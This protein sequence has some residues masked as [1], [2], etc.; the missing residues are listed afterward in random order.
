MTPENL[1]SEWAR[2]LVVSLADAGLRDLVVSPGSRSTPVV[3]AAL[4]S[5]RLRMHSVV[6]ERSAG[7]FALGRAK[8]TGSPAAVL[9]TS[10][11]AAANYMPAVVEAASARVPLLVITADRPFELHD[12]GAAQTMDQ[13][14]LYGTYARRFVDLGMPDTER[15]ALVALRRRAAQ[16]IADTLGPEP[17][18]VHVNVRARKPLEPV[19][20]KSDGARALTHAIDDALRTPLPRHEHGSKQPAQGAID[21]VARAARS[22]KAG[23]IVCGPAEI[24]A[25]ELAARVS[26]IAR[27]TGF[28]VY[29]EA[30]SQLRFARTDLPEALT[31]DALDVLLRVPSFRQ[32]FA[33]D[34]VL[35]IG[36]PPTSGAWER[37]VAERPSLERHVVARAGWPDPASSA[38]SLIIADVACALDALA[39][40]LPSEQ[41]PPLAFAR[42]LS[43][44]NRAAWSAVADV[45]AADE[46]LSEG[47]ALRVVAEA[48]PEGA[49]LGLGNSLPVR[50]A[51]VFCRARAGADIAVWSQRGVSGIDGVVSG[52]AGAADASGRPTVLV[53]GDVSA[54]H[55]MGGLAV[56][57]LVHTPFIVVVLNNAGGRIFEQLPL[58]AAGLDATSESFWTTPHHA[59]FEALA[60]VFDVPYSKARTATELSAAL[61]DGLSRAGCTFVEAVV[62]PHGARE[63][64]ARVGAAVEAALSGS[65]EPQ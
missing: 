58:A 21:C 34:V 37:L 46:R 3:A 42:E 60:G 15:A 16:C 18:P 8:A 59:N 44:L 12:C 28:P 64:Y 45:L 33:P 30:T 40:A 43:R 24:G 27:A 14:R 13:T 51:D 29:A 41:T 2:L 17:G 52:A 62:P 31:L 56:A 19:A 61:R 53:V 65:G 38:R 7:F 55:D 47:A 23:V 35:Q 63:Q 32:A 4:A 49:L 1:L 6:D 22:A 25:G 50:H 39:K 10:G 20:G 5:K 36:E 54:I 57:K 26:A 9:C 11:S 48:L